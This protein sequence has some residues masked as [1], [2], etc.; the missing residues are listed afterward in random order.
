MRRYVEELAGLDDAYLHEPWL[1]PEDERDKLGYPAPI[2][3]QHDA[4]HRMQSARVRPRTP[5]DRTPHNRR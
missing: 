1:L 3:D 4:R 5:Q 2:V